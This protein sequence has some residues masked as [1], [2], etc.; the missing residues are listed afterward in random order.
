VAR[1]DGADPARFVSVQAAALAAEPLGA[2]TLLVV[3]LGGEGEELV[4]RV[5][6]D[7]RASAGEGVTLWFDLTQA[8][9]FDP[10][11]TRALTRSIET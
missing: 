8:H 10:Q 2:E 4:A 6:R 11:P 5:G 9:L 1:P 7:V 3:S